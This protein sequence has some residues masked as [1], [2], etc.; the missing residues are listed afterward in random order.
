MKYRHSLND[1]KSIRRN[2]CSVAYPRSSESDDSTDIDESPTTRSFVVGTRPKRTRFRMK[3]A[4]SKRRSS[5][6]HVGSNPI[7][8]EMIRAYLESINPSDP[9]ECSHQANVTPPR[10]R[11][12]MKVGLND[13]GEAIVPIPYLGIRPIYT[14]IPP[15][16]SQFYDKNEVF[17]MDIDVNF[18]LTSLVELFNKVEIKSDAK[19]TF[20]DTTSHQSTQRGNIKR[21]PRCRPFPSPMALQRE[22]MTYLSDADMHIDSNSDE[23]NIESPKRYS[24]PSSRPQKLFRTIQFTQENCSVTPPHAPISLSK[25]PAIGR[26][27]RPPLQPRNQAENLP[28]P[29]VNR[30]ATPSP[31]ICSKKRFKIPRLTPFAR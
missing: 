26:R 30:N 12:S 27:P 14:P 13:A 20:A 28:P 9:C 23:D 18:S 3:H 7:T 1:P 10:S 6:T 24:P 19:P 16:L 15:S 5:N 8:P 29:S 4:K 2:H 11:M 17:Q 22:H 25:G 31:Q 21:S